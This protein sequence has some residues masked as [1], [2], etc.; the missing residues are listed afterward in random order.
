MVASRSAFCDA[1][2]TKKEISPLPVP[3]IS[4][5]IVIQSAEVV[6]VQGHDMDDDVIEIVPAPPALGKIVSLA[7]KE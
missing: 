7:D 1:A 5:V 4:D 3:L 6:A 2:P